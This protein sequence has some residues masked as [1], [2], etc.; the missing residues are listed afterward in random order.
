[1]RSCAKER[2]TFL[3]TP[4]PASQIYYS[5]SNHRGP[6][7]QRILI[8]L[9]QKG[10]ADRI[11]RRLTSTPTRYMSMIHTPHLSVTRTRY[12]RFVL[13]SIQ[14]SGGKGKGE[15]FHAKALQVGR[16]GE[17]CSLESS[18]ASSSSFPYFY[19]LTCLSPHCEQ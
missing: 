19:S 4:Q 10:I 15:E 9:I 17:P 16:R 14:N 2:K 12:D 6:L 5:A 8:V 3:F 18:P 11:L 7:Y 1:M 13:S